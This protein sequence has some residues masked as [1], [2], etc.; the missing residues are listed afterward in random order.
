MTRVKEQVSEPSFLSSEQ[1][2]PSIA[3]LG[4]WQSR[5]GAA[6]LEG[7]AGAFRSHLSS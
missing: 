5:F 6:V 4:E 7:T 1:I 3:A 2:S